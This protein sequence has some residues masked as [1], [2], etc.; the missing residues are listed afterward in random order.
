V[1][2]QNAGDVERTLLGVSAEVARN[3]VGQGRRDQPAGQ[4]PRQEMTRIL[5]ANSS[6]LLAALS[7]KSKEFS[8]EVIK[9]TT[10]R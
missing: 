6:T 3:F 1:L 4:R 10:M 2:K 7:G 9:A 5:D 8:T